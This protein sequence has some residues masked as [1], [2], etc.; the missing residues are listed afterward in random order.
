MLNHK[1]RC[2]LWPFPGGNKRLLNTLDQIKKRATGTPE[3][4]PKKITKWLMSKYE[5]SKDTTSGYKQVATKLDVFES[6]PD[7]N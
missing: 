6:L 2:A 1:R 4:D 7:G 3:R 5:F